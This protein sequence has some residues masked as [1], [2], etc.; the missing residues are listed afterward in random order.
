MSYKSIFLGGVVLLLLIGGCGLKE[1]VVQKESKSFLWF[2]GDTH[3]AIVYIDDLNP[4][5]LNES[6]SSANSEVENNTNKSGQV[7]YQISPGKH[8]VVVKKSGQEVVNRNILL[9]SGT[10]K[11]IQIP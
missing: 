6:S 2:T 3:N 10:T 1:G 9:G 11:E 4:I 7:H 8:S 5:T